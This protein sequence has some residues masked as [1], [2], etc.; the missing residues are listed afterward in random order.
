MTVQILEDASREF[1]GDPQYGLVTI[2]KAK[3]A[4][5]RGKADEALTLLQ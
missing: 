3:L 2:A 4:L 1:Q 5:A